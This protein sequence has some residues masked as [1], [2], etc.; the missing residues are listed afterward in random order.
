MLTPGQEARPGS[1][2]LSFVPDF[3]QRTRATY[4]V[5]LVFLPSRSSRQVQ[6]VATRRVHVLVSPE[7]HHRSRQPRRWGPGLAK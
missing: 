2:V 6:T 5:R 3:R 4:E 7:N 1:N